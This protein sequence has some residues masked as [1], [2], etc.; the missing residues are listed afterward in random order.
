MS[1]NSKS[2]PPSSIKVLLLEKINQSAVSAFKDAGYDIKEIPKSLSEDELLEEIENVHILC[3][4][5]KTKVASSHIKKAKKLLGIG[6]FGV[7][8]NQVDKDAARAAGISVFNA[9]FASTRSVAELAVA[10]VMNLARKLGDCN[11]NMH[12]GRWE[13]SPKGAFEVRDKV[14]GLVGYGHIGQQVGLLAEAMGLK[15]VF[16]DLM[17]RLPLG[18]A[19]QLGSMKEVFENSDYVSLH[20]PALPSG[21]PLVGKEEISWMKPGSY[22]LNLSRGSL[23]CMDSLKEALE[24]GQLAGAMLDVYPD[25]P[26]TSS[27]DYSSKLKGVSNAFLT[28]HIGGSTQ[29]AQKN[30]GLEVATTLIKFVNNGQSHGS[31]N[32]PQ[33]LL[34]A[35]PNSSRILNIHRNEPGVLGKITN[36]CSDLGVNIDSQYLSTFKEVGYL[37][38]DVSADKSAE[39]A[40]KIKDLPESIKTRT[41]Y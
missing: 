5:S 30:I 21:E 38:M 8:T 23:V 11:N 20:L 10:G 13:K 19:R 31:V 6:C 15:I 35:F 17:A 40:G 34:P 27:E 32:F 12:A 18:G 29:E 1:S 41:L 3:I 14:L 26:R 9:P 4:R 7:G 25:E 33:V 16:S 22:I 36:L 24:S 37:I 28:P 39:L 2:F